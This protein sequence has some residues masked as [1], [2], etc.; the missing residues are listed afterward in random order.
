MMFG[1]PAGALAMYHT[2]KDNKKKMQ[3]V[4]DCGTFASFFTG[5]TGPLNSP[6]SPGS[7]PLCCPCTADGCL[8]AVAAMSP[9]NRRV[10][11]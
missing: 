4:S 7:G 5:V 1:L 11:F 3:Q 8:L 2:A 6:S 9:C 10:Q